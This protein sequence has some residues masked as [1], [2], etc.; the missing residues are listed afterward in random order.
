MYCEISRT[1]QTN[2]EV[3]HQ[4]S[5]SLRLVVRN[6]FKQCN[7]KNCPLLDH[8]IPIAIWLTYGNN[9]KHF[10]FE[11]N[12]TF[13]SAA[14]IYPLDQIPDDWNA[15]RVVLSLTIWIQYST[16]NIIKKNPENPKFSKMFL[17][18]INCDVLFQVGSH[19]IGSHMAILSISSP[20]FAAMFRHQMQEKKNRKVILKDITNDN[21][22]RFLFFLYSGRLVSPMDVDD[23]ISLY[24]VAHKY[25]VLD[26]MEECI[27][28]IST[29]ITPQ[30][31]I[32]LLEW[33]NFF[34]IENLQKILITFS[35]HHFKEVKSHEDW[36]AFWSS[37][38]ELAHIIKIRSLSIVR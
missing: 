14:F 6:E 2:K 21:L 13:C 31:C 37:R 30:N 19:K 3:D 20:V 7:R 10:L 36:P 18:Q 16:W 24:E 38:P 4:K 35:S 26:L 8:Q 28:F 5:L 23:G 34:S 9:A 32:S 29:K 15:I 12:R 17:E 11:N 25:H 22:R 33:A 27:A 1:D